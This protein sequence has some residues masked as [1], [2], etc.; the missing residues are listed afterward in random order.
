MIPI[1]DGLKSSITLLQQRFRRRLKPITSM[2]SKGIASLPDELLSPIFEFTACPGEGTRQGVWLSHVSRR[3]RNVVLEARHLW[4]TLD[5]SATENELRACITRSG[6]ETDL[7][8]VIHGT[9]SNTQFHDFLDVCLP[10]AHRWSTLTASSLLDVDIPYTVD[11]LL[12]DMFDHRRQHEL[13]FPRLQQLRVMQCRSGA[14][15]TGVDTWST[16]QFIPSW[17]TPHLRVMRCDEYIPVPSPSYSTLRKF[18]ASFSLVTEEYEFQFQ[19]LF[20]FLTSLSA[21]TV[22]DLAIR[23]SVNVLQPLHLTSTLCPS[24]TSLTLTFPSS[25]FPRGVDEVV[26][27]FIHSLSMPELADLSTSV[28]LRY[29]D[30]VDDP[31]DSNALRDLVLVL[32]PDPS[33]HPRLTS[34]SIKLSHTNETKDWRWNR[35]RDKSLLIPLDMIPRVST[36]SVTTF[37][38]VC[39]SD[40]ASRGNGRERAALRE[41]RLLECEQLDLKS[42][43]TTIASLKEADAWDT[44]KSFKVERCRY[45]LEYEDVVKVVGEE[46]LSFTRNSL[47]DLLWQSTPLIDHQGIDRRL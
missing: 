15:N 12:L 45:F 40:P 27:P 8:V 1:L 4:T 22:L 34:V 2:L 31:E 35:A 7:H 25:I 18:T 43:E 11:A 42:L 29:D 9:M 37:T 28:E 36:L 13:V 20:L 46:R 19:D 38:N 14:I 44:L 10:M 16:E 33:T 21:V 24:V 23:T 47:E 41:L 6:S 17:I 26:Y 39:F 30:L 3:F 32:L 5:G